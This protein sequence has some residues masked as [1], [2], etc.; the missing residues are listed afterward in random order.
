MTI[1]FATLIFAFLF[2]FKGVQKTP[3]SA[4]C[5]GNGTGRLLLRKQSGLARTAVYQSRI[6]ALRLIPSADD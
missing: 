2:L 6:Y 1:T 4:L 5:N 3:F